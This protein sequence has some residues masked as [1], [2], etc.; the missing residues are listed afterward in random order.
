M[1]SPVCVCLVVF[2]SEL[3]GGLL[4]PVERRVTCLCQVP[5]AG[6]AVCCWMGVKSRVLA[7]RGT[8]TEGGLQSVKSLSSLQEG[9]A[10]L[11]KP[12]SSSWTTDRSP[13]H[14]LTH[15]PDVSVLTNTR[16]ISQTLTPLLVFKWFVPRHRSPAW[17]CAGCSSSS[18]TPGCSLVP[19][20]FSVA[21]AQAAGTHTKANS[22]QQIRATSRNYILRQPASC[23]TRGQ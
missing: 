10:G 18:Q 8:Q 3:I 6:G 13:P 2:P 21:P 7:V 9:T 19:P 22:F 20:Q 17:F 14:T 16:T 11:G 15:T 23:K 5:P 1:K 12:G 4:V